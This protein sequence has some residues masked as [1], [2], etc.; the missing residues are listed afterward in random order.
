[1]NDPEQGG[2]QAPGPET[3]VFRPR[4][5]LIWASGFSVLLVVAALIG[6]FSLE[7][8]IRAQ[9]KWFQILTLIFFI[10]VM[11]GLMMGLG[12]CVVRAGPDGL[13]V[14]NGAI[15]RRLRW[16]DIYAIRYRAG[17]PWAYA[18]LD[19][20]DDPARQQLLAIQTTDGRRTHV[21]VRQLRE[22]LARYNPGAQ[23]RPGQPNP[24]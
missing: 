19:D 14:R 11:I 22:M 21:A 15:Q 18:L 24:S 9:F 1:M 12:L 8:G 23:R 20:S 17:D 7:P 6:W 5:L 3:V 4:N 16:S 10:F 13:I 2:N